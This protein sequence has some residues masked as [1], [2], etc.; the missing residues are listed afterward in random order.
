MTTSID[1]VELDSKMAATAR[2][3]SSYSSSARSILDRHDELQRL[4]TMMD[5]GLMNASE[6]Q[7]R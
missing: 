1:Q 2:R 5:L 3:R 4:V 7:V 6:N